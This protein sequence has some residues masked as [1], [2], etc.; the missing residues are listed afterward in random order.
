MERTGGQ[1]A[2]H[3]YVEAY[4]LYGG[5]YARLYAPVSAAV[6]LSRENDGHAYGGEVV[7]KRAQKH[8]SGSRQRPQPS[9]R[10]IILFI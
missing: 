9:R 6:T 4:A 8:A 5:R 7:R 1:A 2:R 3:L 10:S